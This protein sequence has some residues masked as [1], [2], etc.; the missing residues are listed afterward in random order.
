MITIDEILGAAQARRKAT[1]QREHE[2]DLAEATF[3][4]EGAAIRGKQCRVCGERFFLAED[5]P[6]LEKLIQKRRALREVGDD[7]G[8]LL[9]LGAYPEVAMPGTLVFQKE[10]F[11]LEKSL[12]PDLG[13]AMEPLE[14]KPHR[15]GP[16]SDKLKRILESLEKGGL[17]ETRPLPGREE[18]VSYRLTPKGKRE[19]VE[20]GKRYPSEVLVAIQKKRRAWDELGSAGLL[21]LVYEDFSAYAA[22]SEIAD[23]VKKGPRRED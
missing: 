11:L 21:K 6:K 8:V 16:Y 12:A 22:R 2:H 1:R 3:D 19:A 9:L 5:V 18:G 17:I 7:D 14:F 4:I 15:M 10:A 20:A 23:R 13:L